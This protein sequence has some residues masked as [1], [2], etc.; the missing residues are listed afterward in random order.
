MVAIA[1]VLLPAL[2]VLSSAPAIWLGHRG[3]IGDS[4][5][6]WTAYV[7]LDVAAEHLPAV[8]KVLT[9]YLNFWEP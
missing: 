7:P 3:M 2:Y 1:L 4:N 9:W 8:D 5:P 6:L